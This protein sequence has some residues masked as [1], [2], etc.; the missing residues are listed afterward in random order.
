MS[1]INKHGVDMKN[2]LLFQELSCEKAATIQ[3][4]SAL[5]LYQDIDFQGPIIFTD[6]SSPY[7]G[8]LNN[9]QVSS[10]VVNEGIWTFYADANFQGT[11]ITLGRG[12]YSDARTLNIGNDTISSFSRIA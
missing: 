12:T 2:D 8:N 6:S 3:G 10:I 9:D 5:E 7:V 4:G 11:T 1:N